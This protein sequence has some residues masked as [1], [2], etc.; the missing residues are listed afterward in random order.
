MKD[1]H[2]VVVSTVLVETSPQAL[3]LGAACIASSIKQF[4][5]DT[6]DLKVELQDFSL[7]DD[8][9]ADKI[10]QILLNFNASVYCFSL[11]VWNRNLLIQVA[12]KIKEKNSEIICI[13]GGPEVTAHP[14]SFFPDVKTN[15]YPFDYLI[16]GEGEA[17]IGRLINSLFS[18]DVANNNE[19][20]NEKIIYGKRESLKDLSSP[21]LDGTLAP[22]K[23]EGA[24]W[25]LARGCPFKCSYCYESKGEKTVEYF[26]KERIQAELDLFV[27]QNVAQVFVLDPTYNADKS[28]ALEMLKYISKKAKDIFFHFECRAEFID[29]ELA[30]A[31]SKIQCSLQIGLQSASENVL[32]LVNRSFNKKDFIKKVSILNDYGITFGFDLIYGLPGDSFSGFKDSIDFSISLYPNHLELFCLSVLPGTDL[33]DRAQSLELCFE[34]LP[35]Y[36]VIN[37]KTFPKQ[38]IERA[39]KLAKASNLFYSQGRAVPWFVSVIKLL[40]IKPSQLFEEFETYIEK[41]NYIHKD[42]EELQIKY[43]TDKIKK[44]QMEKYLNLVI[45]I[46]KIN[47]AFSR[48]YAEGETTQLNL[49]YH[50]EDLLCEYSQDLIYFL[51]NAQMQK[52]S[53]KVF[54]SK[55]GPTFSFK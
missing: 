38:D 25:E 23:Y 1:N 8:I 46:V 10:T 39:A 50:P 6:S 15:S 41:E 22:S 45:D 44:N 17:S 4:C 49:H 40:K 34:E 48:A 29:K 9:D 27:K 33:Y 54:D 5:K 51:Q 31:F 16:S 19:R 42:I 43:L 55:D 32:R 37:S 7:E 11:F 18:N 36:N 26:P 3:P 2:T 13:A 30:S 28:R 24:L 47:G 20:S 52:C 21:Y 35:P 14:K 12:L 53:I